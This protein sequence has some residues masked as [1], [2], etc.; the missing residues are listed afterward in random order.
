[1][2]QAIKQ[3]QI[4]FE[5]GEVPVG[6]VI[7]SDNQ[8][9]AKSYNQTQQLNDVTAHAEMIAITSAASCL[10]SK[11]L[12]DCTIYVTLEP[13]VMCAGALYWSQIGKLVYGAE[14]KKRGFMRIGKQLVHPKTKVAWGI[15]QE[16]CQN[17]LQQFFLTKR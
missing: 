11:Y 1:M 9:I 5:Q 14:D 10:G 17:M 16:T 3:A 8:I 7:V 4:A 12:T 15:Q 6:A 13:C 2:Q